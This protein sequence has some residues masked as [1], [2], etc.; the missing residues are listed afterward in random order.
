ML[1]LGTMDCL[2]NAQGTINDFVGT[3]ICDVSTSVITTRGDCPQDVHGRINELSKMNI[4]D[5]AANGEG[6]VDT[7]ESK[8]SLQSSAALCRA[9]EY[10]GGSIDVAQ[11]AS[12]PSISISP[13][14]KRNHLLSLLRASSG[15]QVAFPVLNRKEKRQVRHLHRRSVCLGTPSASF[16]EYTPSPH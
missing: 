1:N 16:T 2:E 15:E 6:E 13:C 12:L 5:V 14:I 11:V 10:A 7:E 9:L 8:K 3:M 4:Q